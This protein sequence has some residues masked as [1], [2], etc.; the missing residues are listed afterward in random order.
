MCIDKLE[1]RFQEQRGGLGHQQY[2]LNREGI[3][4]GVNPNPQWV[5]VDGIRESLRLAG[6]DL[7]ERISGRGQRAYSLIE[8]LN[9]NGEKIGVTIKAGNMRGELNYAYVKSIIANPARFLGWSDFWAVI[10]AMDGPNSENRVIERGVI[11]RI[12]YACDYLVPI[13]EIMRGLYVSRSQNLFAYQD[14]QDDAYGEYRWNQG[15]FFSFKVGGKNKSF[16]I[17]DKGREEIKQLRRLERRLANESG[18]EVQTDDPE[19]ED[20]EDDD[21]WFSESDTI[22]GQDIQ[23]RLTA[24][25][26]N[27]AR[28][29][30]EPRT[31]IERSLITPS[32]IRNAWGLETGV[33]RLSGLMNHL[34]SIQ[35]GHYTP[36]YGV[37]LNDIEMRG[38]QFERRVLEAQNIRHR[39]DI[40]LLMPLIKEMGRS[41]WTGHRQYFEIYPW[42]G[43]AQPTSVFKMRLFTWMTLPG[44]LTSL[45]ANIPSSDKRQPRRRPLTRWPLTLTAC[46][47]DRMGTRS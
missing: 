13:Q 30:H 32:V 23:R 46:I 22:A 12:D 6:Y 45:G 18:A 21:T 40:G 29:S 31:R 28:L 37:L 9:P 24:L 47:R 11:H 43:R 36:F 2:S 41:F 27:I 33:P 16:K 44:G 1:I 19:G 4:A 26:A 3:D 25:R 17:Y 10:E 7:S 20:D 39:V 35:I 34:N 38:R 14:V 42:S 5:N 15:V 8:V